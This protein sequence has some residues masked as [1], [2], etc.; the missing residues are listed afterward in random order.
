MKAYCGSGGIAPRILTLALDEERSASR[1]GCFTPRERSP[2]THRIG[3][4][5]GLRAGL[6]AVV[7]ENF[8]P[9]AGTRTPDHPGRSP[10]LYHC[11]PKGKILPGLN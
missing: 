8:L 5:V 2:G 3:G 1:P 4:C 10:A 11:A 9:P 7:R 6:D